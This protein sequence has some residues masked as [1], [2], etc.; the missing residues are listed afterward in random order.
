M[1]SDWTSTHVHYHDDPIGL[2][3]DGVRPL[4]ARVN[5][6]VPE[7]YFVR[8]WRQGPHLRLSFRTS[9]Q[10]Y[11]SV[12]GP[13]VAETIGEYL[14][15]HP[16]SANLDPARLLHQ[17]QR[18]AELEGERGPLVP[19]YPDNS[20]R[21]AGYDMRLPMLESPRAAEF[22]AGFHVDTNAPTFAAL[23]RV[24]RR[25]ASLPGIAFDLM[26]ATAHALVPDGITRGF[27]SFRS[28][29]EAFLSFWPEG[30][31]LRRPWDDHYAEYADRLRD[32]VRGV[33]DELTGPREP[34]SDLRRWVE[35]LGARVRR[36]E[37]L[38]AAGLTLGLRPREAAIVARGSSVFHDALESNPGWAERQESLEFQ[39]Y[40]LALNLLY[41]NLTR[42]G[43]APVQRFRLCHLAANA[44]EDAY[45][46][47]ALD[48]VRG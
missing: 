29:A 22:I 5:A 33:V 7:A 37:E 41:L 44:V 19:W 8:H 18:L 48:L 31:G 14:R 3:L 28:H 17:H 26:I 43:L 46:V 27:V 16:S 20:I 36:G 24:R 15:A 6:A 13:A 42:L 35:V 25:E 23:T 30:R 47:S 34:A 38:L 10:I 45:G 40:R 9:P 32:R 2:I 1:T 12:I 4:F 11:E 39:R 21:R